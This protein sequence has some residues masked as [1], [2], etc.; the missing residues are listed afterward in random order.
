MSGI[1]PSFHRTEIAASRLQSLAFDSDGLVDWVAGRRY[2]L[3]GKTE[4]LNTGNSDSS[5]FDAAVGLGS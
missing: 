1:N 3:D 5:R 2:R 4:I